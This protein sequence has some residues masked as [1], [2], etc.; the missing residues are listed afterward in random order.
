MSKNLNRRQALGVLGG[1]F[2]MGCSEEPDPDR[3]NQDDIALLAAQQQ[4]ELAASGKGPFG[5]HR[6][7]GYRGLAELPWF[8]LN[9]EG[10][11]I[12]VDDSI[13]KAIDVHC[14]LGM[15]VLFKPHLDLQKKTARVKHLLDCDAS[16]PGCKL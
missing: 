3:Y 8:E 16:N 2:L 7:Q 15:S 5:V 13:P 1:M 6:Y 4:Q 9:K 14:H 12:C 10:Q 11:L